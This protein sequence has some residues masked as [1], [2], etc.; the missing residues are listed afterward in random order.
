M[1]F[2]NAAKDFFIDRVKH[3]QALPVEFEYDGAVF[4]LD[5]VK[6]RLGD[7][8]LNEVYRRAFNWDEAQDYAAS[9][10]FGLPLQSARSVAE[11]LFRE[12][13][14]YATIG[15]EIVALGLTSD[16]ENERRFNEALSKY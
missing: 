7:D 16:L 2:E 8:G 10:G 1:S 5:E 4:D 13:D 14:D 9:H 11:K 15:H 3:F 12:G 6:A